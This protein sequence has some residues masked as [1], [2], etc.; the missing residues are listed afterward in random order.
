VQK[1][2]EPIPVTVVIPIKNQAAVLAR[3][4]DALKEVAAV[5]VVDSKSTDNTAEV[6]QTRGAEILQFDCKGGFPKKRNWVLQ[7]YAFNTDWVLFLDADEILTPPFISELRREL[8]CSRVAGY[9]LCYTNFFEGKP[10]HFGI[11]QRKLALFRVGAGSYER[12]EDP[13]WSDLDMEVHE[14]PILEGPVGEIKAPILHEDL[15]PLSRFIERHT[16]Y[17]T[18][19]ARRYLTDFADQT[20]TGSVLTFRQR[21]KY[22]LIESPM[23][24]VFYFLYTYIF[25]AGFLD[26][27]PGLHYARY[28]AK[29]FLDISRKIREFRSTKPARIREGLAPSSDRD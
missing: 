5:L 3:C 23:L 4:L 29:Y 20:K 13:G 26:G 24:S 10:L 21:V 2:N 1:T 6:A 25:R 27:T 17:S 14:H 9:W 28:K 19:E 11:P 16:K 22:S 12:I 15:S 8:P 18:W 7:T